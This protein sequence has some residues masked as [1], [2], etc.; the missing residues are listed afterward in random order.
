MNI[1]TES[2][3]KYGSGSNESNENSNVNKDN[4]YYKAE[5]YS[6][7]KPIKISRKFNN[8]ESNSDEG[9]KNKNG[10]FSR[11]EKGSSFSDFFSNFLRKE[12]V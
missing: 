1:E 8:S 11:R 10:F 2:D 12:N 5:E 4:I 3:G 6:D 7:L 9:K